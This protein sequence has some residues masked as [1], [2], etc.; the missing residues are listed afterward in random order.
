MKI[1]LKRCSLCHGL[2]TPDIKGE[3]S[4][5]E[6][7]WFCCKQHRKEY[8]DGQTRDVLSKMSGEEKNDFAPYPA[9]KVLRQKR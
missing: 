9:Q 1:E 6:H 3:I 5:F 8:A 4:V 2:F 7:N